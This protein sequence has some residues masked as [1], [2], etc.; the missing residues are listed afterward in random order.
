MHHPQEK[1]SILIQEI[2][3]MIN[4]DARDDARIV[5]IEQEVQG[6]ANAGCFYQ[7]K[8]V[9]GMIA[10][11]RGDVNGAR[12]Q[13]EAAMR[14]SGND[15]LVRLNFARALSN[16]QQIREAIYHINEA[17]RYAPDNLDVL[18]LALD[19]HQKAYDAQGSEVLIE[20][21]SRLGMEHLIPEETITKLNGLADLLKSNGA[22]WEDITDR[23]EL[24]TGVLLKEGRHIKYAVETSFGDSVLMDFFIEAD[25]DAAASS[26]NAIHVAIANQSYNPADRIISFSCTPA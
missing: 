6:I 3:S 13:F 8:Q 1:A 2:N 4:N 23:I 20:R 12:Q 10:S 9:L 19:I 17:V 16:I 22:S 25:E 21:I 24:A 14:A 26:E 18:L 7:A 15:I 5:A 11:M